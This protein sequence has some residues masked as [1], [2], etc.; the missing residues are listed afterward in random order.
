MTTNENASDYINALEEAH[1]ADCHATDDPCYWLDAMSIYGDPQI[2]E[3]IRALEE[4]VMTENEKMI[5][6]AARRVLQLRHP[7]MT[8][9]LEARIDEDI[10]YTDLVVDVLTNIGIKVA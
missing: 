7:Q 5:H 2:I 3:I 1:A 8:P 9:I 6:A 10:E 4:R